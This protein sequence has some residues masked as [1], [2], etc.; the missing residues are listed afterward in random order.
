MTWAL[1]LLGCT[2]VRGRAGIQTLECLSLSR[3]PF[4][5]AVPSCLLPGQ[6]QLCGER[7]GLLEAVVL[8]SSEGASQSSFLP[9]S[10]VMAWHWGGR[11]GPMEGQS[12]RGGAEQNSSSP[13]SSRRECAD[14]PKLPWGPYLVPR[15]EMLENLPLGFTLLPALPWVVLI[16]VPPFVITGICRTLFFFQCLLNSFCNIY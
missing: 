4:C 2:L 13:S 1:C 16:S 14:S 3:C 5:G 10:P 11:R 7:F 15:S 12:Y 6:P 9:A 8:R